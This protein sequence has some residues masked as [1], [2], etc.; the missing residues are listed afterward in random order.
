MSASTLPLTKTLTVPRAQIGVFGRLARDPLAWISTILFGVIL[1]S[2]LLAPLLAPQDPNA[3]ALE[4]VLAPIGPDHL[5]GGDSA[6]RDVFSRL[7]FAGQFSLAGAAIALLVALVIGVPTGLIAGFYGRTF[8]TVANW[9]TNLLMALPAILVL[10]AVRAVV[11][12]SMWLSMAIFGILLSPGFFRL[13]RNSVGAVRNELY[14]DAARV[15]GL[16][17]ARIIGRHVL[18]VVRAPIFIQSAMVAGVAIGIQA[19]LEFL[20]LGDISIPTWGGMLN[21][22]FAKIYQAPTLILWPGLV[23]GVTCLSLAL[24]ANSVRDALDDSRGAAATPGEDDAVDA[25]NE[26]VPPVT[27]PGADTLLSVSHLRVGY[28]QNGGGDRVVVKDVSLHVER[29]EV[30]GLVGESGSGKSQTAFSIMGLLPTPGRVIS[31]EIVVD[32][33]NVVDLSARERRGLRGRRI[34]YIPQEPMSNL[35]PSFTI[36]SQL[37]EPMT[38]VLGLSRAA[39]KEKALALL[40][41]VGI[42]DPARVFAA[43][44]HEISGG[45]AQR[46]LIAGAVSCDPDLLIADEPTTALDVTVQAEVLDLLRDLQRERRMAVILVTH[47]FGVVADICDRV[48]VMRGGRIVEENSVTELFA[49]P[50]HPYTRMLLDST[51]DDVEPRSQRDRA[52]SKGSNA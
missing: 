24:L 3:S 41:R 21:E 10:L 33:R 4:N 15:S 43:Y 30:L 19:G 7:L 52:Q 11:G 26:P 28:P 14:V 23:I 8:D 6:G 37:V 34:G 5:L 44:P 2:A 32:G 49:R 38:A 18:F 29:G 25:V 31:G 51:L 17:D 22:G 50:R 42:A 16:S 45:M 13:V 47:N 40:E 27:S 12:P 35:D 20:G 9:T 36:G 48:A 1:L 46:V 39:A